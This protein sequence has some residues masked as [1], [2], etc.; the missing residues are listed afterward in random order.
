MRRWNAGTTYVRDSIM[1]RVNL[2]RDQ[3]SH[4]LL[5]CGMIVD[6]QRARD[7]R[8]WASGGRF[9][10]RFLGWQTTAAVTAAAANLSVRLQS[11]SGKIMEGQKQR[12]EESRWISKR[13]A[14]ASVIRWR[15]CVAAAASRRPAATSTASRY[16]RR[17]KLSPL[18]G[19]R[20]VTFGYC[21]NFYRKSILLVRTDVKD[22]WHVYSQPKVWFD[23]N[24]ST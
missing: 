14:G 20:R 6:T 22:G 15:V 11:I 19:R 18:R 1:S 21:C 12:R 2:I 24:F 8:D 17:I 16:D 13:E 9:G 5:G 4:I 10:L 23:Q 3:Q 7:D